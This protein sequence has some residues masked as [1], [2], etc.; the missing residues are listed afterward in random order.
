M[1]ENTATCR[2]HEKYSE[3][4]CNNPAMPEE[5]EGLCILHSQVKDKNAESFR[6]ALLAR[7]EQQMDSKSYDFSGILFPSPFEPK[8]V[9]SSMEFKKT[10]TFYKAI[11]VYTAKFIGATFAG[12]ADFV[13]ATFINGADF[14]GANFIDT[15]FFNDST[16]SRKADFRKASFMGKVDFT[17]ATFDKMERAF[18]F[19]ATFMEAADFRGATFEGKAIFQGARF[20]EVDFSWAKFRKDVS[21]YETIFKNDA[22]FLLVTF[23]E[24]ASFNWAVIEGRMAFHRLNLPKDGESPL[25]VFQAE[26][27][28]LQFRTGGVLRFQDLSL[29]HCKFEETDLRQ[30]EFHHVQW[31]HYRG[32]QA[33]YDEVLLRQEEKDYPW[34]WRWL[35]YAESH[36]DT[37]SSWT[38]KY[39]EVERLYRDL[40]EN[41]ERARDYK[42]MGDF[43]YGEMEMHRR[44]SKWRWFPFYWYNLYWF[45]SGYG[46]RPFRALS[47]LAGFLAVLPL[48]IWFLG[49]DISLQGQPPGFWESFSFMFEK[50]T[51]QR[52]APPPDLNLL[53]R[54]ISYLGLLLIP[55]QTALFLLALRNR[56]GRRR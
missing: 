1:S 34:F 37:P 39:G 19:E 35:F 24:R 53:G 33:V 13:N 28:Y 52:P 22:N 38:D 36:A 51:L 47:C 21:F 4:K 9:F 42:K 40:Q 50:A 6:S 54:F 2:I 10:I 15:A 31:H 18:F 8:A 48:A 32:R 29:A 5:P 55:G 49:M 44:A 17:K 16:F 11:F 27:Q 41:Y 25:S 46:E 56:L 14:S 7:W 26:F 45:L 30:M 43:H 12:D 3:I 23:S 20:N